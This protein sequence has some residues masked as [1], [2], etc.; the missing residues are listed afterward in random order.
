MHIWKA[1]TAQEREAAQKEV[2]ALNAER[3]PK[4]REE[5][6]LATAMRRMNLR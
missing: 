4:C 1:K 5:W 6:E 2:D 3:E